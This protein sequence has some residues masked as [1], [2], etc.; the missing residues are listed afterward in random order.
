ME[1]HHKFASVITTT[2]M[3]PILTKLQGK[4]SRLDASNGSFATEPHASV[5]RQP[6]RRLSRMAQSCVLSAASGAVDLALDD[7]IV[8]VICPTCRMDLEKT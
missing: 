6:M 3:R 5:W 7:G 4:A 2:V 8:P 1:R